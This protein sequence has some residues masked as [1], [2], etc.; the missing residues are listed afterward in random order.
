M[1]SQINRSIDNFLYQITI[2]RLVL[3]VLVAL[4]LIAVILSGFHLLPFSPVAFLFS[5]SFILL[6]SKVSNDIFA[7]YFLAPT[8]VES[9][10]I[11]ALILSLI[12]SPPSTFSDIIFLFWAALLATASK[13]IL[14]IGNK[15][16]FNPVAV[17]V[18]LTAA[19]FGASASWWIGNSYLALPVAIGS[20]LIIKKIRRQNLVYSFLFTVIFLSLGF[21]II[22]HQNIFS[23]LSVLFLHSSLLFF[24]G[25]MLTEPLTSPAT[26]NLQFIFG[27]LVGFL[28]VP[29]V[30]FGSVYFTPEQALIFGNLFAYITGPKQKL[31]LYLKEKIQLTPDTYD[32]V[33]SPDKKLNFTPGQ[34]F[35]WTLPHP[36]PDDRGNRRY[37]TIASS[38]TEKDLR[39]GVK[40]HPQGSTYKKALL[41][42]DKLPIV[43][44]QLAGD[45]TLPKNLNDKYVFVAGGI[46]ITPFRSMIKYLTDTQI[47]MDII[48]L[49][50]NKNIS[51]AVYRDVFDVSGIKT[52]YFN[53]SES[54]HLGQN[55]LP[56]LI[57]D[58]SSRTFYISGPHG[59]VS[60]TESLLK[61]LYIRSDHIKTDFFPGFA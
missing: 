11:T 36:H 2:Y 55:N 4:S 28:F 34:Y 40:F 53:T 49:Y 33:F 13:Y 12:I 18:V 14:A 38:P 52:I 15:H 46:G 5:L 16:L 56:N 48:L 17:A 57:P 21:N 9:V 7:R 27:T 24:T 8:N 39:I 1:L 25:V 61:N 59:L 50:I 47:K 60:S 31:I 6:I 45:F 44:S 23:T 43:A 42:L 51:E 20:Y 35:E 22:N 32:F 54:G 3:Y 41:S 10:Y 26:D 58:Y 30:H 19:G 29:Q 37:L